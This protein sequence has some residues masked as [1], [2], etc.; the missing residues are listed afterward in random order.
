MIS[1]L[2][3]DVW[4][5]SMIFDEIDKPEAELSMRF[6]SPSSRAS[7]V[8]LVL[9]GKQTARIINRPSSK[10]TLAG[11][12]FYKTHIVLVADLVKPCVNYDLASECSGPVHIHIRVHI[13]CT[14]I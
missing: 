11:L 6:T 12:L 9:T 5:R 10:H 3:S 13:H 1:T 8:E 14:N 2:A 4:E 7:S